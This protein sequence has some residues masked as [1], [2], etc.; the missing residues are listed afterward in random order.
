MAIT[1][2]GELTFTVAGGVVNENKSLPG[3]YAEDDIVL[4]V[5]ANDGDLSASAPATSGY[6]SLYAPVSDTPV[7]GN[8]DPA[9]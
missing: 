3:A 9:A 6:S 2:V 4:I 1:K 8:D 5:Q 7:A